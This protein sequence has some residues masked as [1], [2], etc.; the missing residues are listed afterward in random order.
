[1]S[2]VLYRPFDRFGSQLSGV[3]HHNRYRRGVRRGAPE[4]AAPPPYKKP[5]LEP[6]ADAPMPR[7]YRRTRL[8]VKDRRR[9]SRRRGV[10]RRRIP[11]ALTSPTKLVRIKA[12][13]YVNHA[14]TAALSNTDIQIT[15]FDD[16]FGITNAG[17]PLGY[18]QWK[19]LYRQAYVVGAKTTARVHNNGTSACMI[20]ITPMKPAQGTTALANYEY[21]MELP[22]TK[23]RIL[24]PDVDHTVI[25]HQV[26]PKR[27]LPVTKIRD[28]DDLKFNLVTETPPSTLAYF[29]VWS[30]PL[31]E[32][33]AYD[34]DLVITAEYL[35][36]LVD[37]IV[38][39]R[40]SET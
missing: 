25:S 39:A 9:T 11:R 3:V 29:H 2:H 38:P 20:G 6:R 12:V 17:Q 32:A 16:P 18:D 14:N 1:M 26:S 15:S 24:S 34:I 13:Q 28:N 36:L 21:Y 30:Q 40:S 35:V 10:I 7:T 23:A 33:A 19:A 5:R 31:D 4:A 37:P 8:G 22:Q 27:F